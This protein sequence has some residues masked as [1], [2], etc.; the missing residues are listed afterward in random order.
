LP[1][2]DERHKGPI[3]RI[4]S[5][6]PRPV[7]PRPVLPR[8]VYQLDKAESRLMATFTIANAANRQ[9]STSAVVLLDSGST[10]ELTL[11]ARKAIQ[12]GL[13]P[14][15]TRTVA[16]SAANERKNMLIFDPVHV[17]A[18]FE[19]AGADVIEVSDILSVYV[20]EDDYMEALVH[21]LEQEREMNEAL[22]K[23]VVSFDD[24]GGEE[25]PA[26]TAEGG[27][28]PAPDLEEPTSLGGEPPATTAE[29]G[30]PTTSDLGGEEPPA[31]TVPRRRNYLKLSPIKH[32]HHDD[33]D[34][35]AIFGMGALVKLR[36]VV[37]A[38]ESQLELAEEDIE[39]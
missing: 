8:T 27:I 7:L 3:N 31:A 21:K 33:F 22:R 38:R 14:I 32:R 25:L 1:G 19:A 17:I 23:H 29:A 18:K 5:D 13:T 12:L 39:I 15:G 9:L 16:T 6:R 30:I 4:I 35:R 28:P 34:Q 26:A 37:N 10:S 2:C 36:L 20:Y 11:S 24:L